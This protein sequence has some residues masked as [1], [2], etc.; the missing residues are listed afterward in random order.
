L[1]SV[2]EKKAIKKKT[3]RYG[4]SPGALV[5]GVGITRQKRRRE[6]RTS[7]PSSPSRFFLMLSSPLTRLQH[8]IT[9]TQ[10]Y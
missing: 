10:N 4:W 1:C 8:A 6:E 3:K 7:N 5:R 9:Y 2:E